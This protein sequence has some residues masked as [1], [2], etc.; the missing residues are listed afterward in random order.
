M[1]DPTNDLSADPAT[2]S[3]TNDAVE[4]PQT[5]EQWKKVL[6]PEQF[7]VTRKHGTERA[8][9]GEYWNNK[10]DGMYHCVCCGM[11]LFDSETKFE[12]GHGLAQLLSTGRRGQRWHQAGQYLL[13]A[14]H[15]SPLRPM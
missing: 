11:P 10:R 7:N 3:R 1:S 6:T 4:L 8:F 9:T 14:A 5:D 2:V 13:H 12:S 15:R